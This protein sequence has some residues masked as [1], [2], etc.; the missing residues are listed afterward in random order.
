MSTI[1]GTGAV[2]HQVSGRHVVAVVAIVASV[3]D[4]EL[5]E[6][7]GA[8][9]T[10]PSQVPGHRPIAAPDTARELVSRAP[11]LPAQ[12]TSKTLCASWKCMT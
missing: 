5:S 2:H 1:G 10:A 4:V 9:A 8:T 6:N 3:A 11:V 7:A 12:S